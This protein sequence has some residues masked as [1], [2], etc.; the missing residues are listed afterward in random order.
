MADASDDGGGTGMSCQ[1]VVVLLVVAASSLVGSDA[2]SGAT[3]SRG[4]VA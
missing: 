2:T 3:D 1:T 4:G